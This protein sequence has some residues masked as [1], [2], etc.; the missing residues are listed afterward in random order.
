MKID[1]KD[2]KQLERFIDE[3]SDRGVARAARSAINDAAFAMRI[4]SRESIQR[5]FEN[6]GRF[7]AGS[8]RVSKATTLDLD[9]MQSEVGSVQ[10]Y[11]DMQEKGFVRDNDLL[12]GVSVPTTY[13]AGQ[14]NASKR[15]RKVL[16]KNR[17]SRLKGLAR[18]GSVARGKGKKQRQAAIFNLSKSGGLGK[19]IV[20]PV[21]GGRVVMRRVSKPTRSRSRKARFKTLYWISK[22]P[23]IVSKTPWMAMALKPVLKSLPEMYMKGLERQYEF[24][25]KK[26]RL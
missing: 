6:R 7:T 19:D 25:R 21:T 23:I 10:F 14:G 17:R 16:S 20:I 13:A 2:M 9:K 22:S 5:S 24:L 11:L 26:N 12:S 15:T 18:S 4:S 8:I 3:V 1:S